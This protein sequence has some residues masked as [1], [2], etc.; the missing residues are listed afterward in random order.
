MEFVNRLSRVLEVVLE[1]VAAVLVVALTAIV[2]Y[3]VFTRYTSR[4]PVWYDEVAAIM[5]VWLTYYA[6]ALAALKRGHIGFDGLLMSLPPR[7][8]MAAALTAEAIVIAFFVLLAWT[9]FVVLQILSGMSLISLRWIPV[10]LTQSVIPVG[11]LL[12]ILA[13]LLSMPGYLAKVRAGVSL[14]HEEIEQAIAEAEREIGDDAER[15][16][17][18]DVEKRRS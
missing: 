10:Q 16:L 1:F 3:A 6:G 4:S 7:A 12:F 8:R 13:E 2:L 18:G 9:G 17:A 14:E 15:I 5:L 11:A